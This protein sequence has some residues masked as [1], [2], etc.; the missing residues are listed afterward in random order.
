M[1]K[2]T[3][4][5]DIEENGQFKLQPDGLRSPE[6]ETIPSAINELKLEKINQRV[7]LISIIIPVLIVVVLVITYLDIK[8][9]V[10]RTEDTGAIEFRKLSSDL[11]SRFSSLSVRQAKI[12][13]SQGK[14]TDQNNHAMA[15]LQVRYEKLQDSVETLERNMRSLKTTT[16]DKSQLNATRE[17]LATQL[18][19][20]VASANASGEQ[21]AAITQALKTQIDGTIRSNTTLQGQL[22]ELETRMAQMADAK[23]DKA[24]VDLAIRLETLKVGNE[25]KARIDALTSRLDQLNRKAAPPSRPSDAPPSPPD[26]ASGGNAPKP[27]AAVIKEQTITQ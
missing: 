12:E 14:L 21:V 10:V 11:E 26:G 25:L 19:S 27:P 4:Q 15:Q 7:T 23:V 20:V 9:R 13:E 6:E 5:E 18:N 17:E 3:M 8:K 22:A 24:A 1:K 16:A 2:T